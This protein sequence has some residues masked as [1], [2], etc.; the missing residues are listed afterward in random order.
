MASFASSATMC[1]ARKHAW[2]K[3]GLNGHNRQNGHNWPNGQT[4]ILAIM[5]IIARYGCQKK[6][7][8]FRNVVTGNLTI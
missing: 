4:A 7:L 1:G 8:G 5:I 3:N 6:R 2:T